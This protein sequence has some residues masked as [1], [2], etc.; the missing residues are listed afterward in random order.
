MNMLEVLDEWF[1]TVL[2]G[3]DNE[4]TYEEWVNMDKWV[5]PVPDPVMAVGFFCIEDFSPFN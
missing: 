2:R 1:R 4:E 5:D 3:G